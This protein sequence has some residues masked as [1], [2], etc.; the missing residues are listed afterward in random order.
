MSRFV[1]LDVISPTWPKETYVGIFNLDL[2]RMCRV[3]SEPE[4]TG[5][6]VLNYG[7]SFYEIDEKSSKKILEIIEPDLTT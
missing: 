3:C 1:K 5:R 7:E 6:V 4:K 2:L